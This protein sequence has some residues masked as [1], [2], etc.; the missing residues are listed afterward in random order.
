FPQQADRLLTEVVECMGL[1]LDMLTIYDIY[2]G[3]GC[4]P[5]VKRERLMERWVT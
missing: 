3:Q 5:N 2:I 4:D 1:K